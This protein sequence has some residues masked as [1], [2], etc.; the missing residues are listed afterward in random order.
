[1]LFRSVLNDD[2]RGLNVGGLSTPLTSSIDTILPAATTSRS[3]VET[4]EYIDRYPWSRES[5][6]DLESSSVVKSLILDGPT[7]FPPRPQRLLSRNYGDLKLKPQIDTLSPLDR[8]PIFVRDL[9]EILFD[10]E[11]T[12]PSTATFD[13]LQESYEGMHSTFRPDNQIIYGGFR[14]RKK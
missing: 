6:L 12:L 13:V 3:V 9:K 10:R 2:F 7:I 14:L 8:N 5:A 1:M 11:I 4:I